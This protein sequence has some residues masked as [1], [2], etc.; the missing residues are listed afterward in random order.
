MDY[1][2]PE[3]YK[4]NNDCYHKRDHAVITFDLV[5]R[6]ERGGVYKRTN[7][8]QNKYYEQ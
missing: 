1:I 5:Q 3:S 4:I 6:F 7:Q 8:Q 2:L